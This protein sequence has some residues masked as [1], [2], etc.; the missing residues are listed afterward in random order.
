MT[1]P[2]RRGDR[3]WRVGKR[4]PLRCVFIRSLPE[5]NLVELRS[6][7]FSEL[8]LVKPKGDIFT[9]RNE[10]AAEI[11][12]RTEPVIQ[13]QDYKGFRITQVARFEVVVRPINDPSKRMLECRT[14][15]EAKQWIDAG[16]PGYA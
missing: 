14:V 15:E 16:E 2:M 10:C 3:V 12:R 9:D 6:S 5:D 1:L 4:Y 8:S 11:E 13:P 7:H